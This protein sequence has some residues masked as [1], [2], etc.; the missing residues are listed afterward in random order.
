MANKFAWDDEEA[1]VDH[2]E[3]PRSPS[4]LERIALLTLVEGLDAP[5]EFTIPAKRVVIGRAQD[6]DLRLPD[7]SVSQHHAC[8]ELAPGGF[9][10]Q[11]LGSRNG[12]CLNGVRVHSAVLH[13][14]D[15]LQLGDVLFSFHEQQITA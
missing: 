1:T 9:T 4:R 3:A 8:I 10:I 2:E 11:D 5:R 15:Q 7:P 6:V 14:G 13:T 12:V